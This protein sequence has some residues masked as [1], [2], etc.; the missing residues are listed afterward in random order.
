[1]VKNMYSLLDLARLPEK[2]P[3][4]VITATTIG[5][6]MVLLEVINSIIG[7]FAVLTGVCLT[8]VLIYTFIKKYRLES[9]KLNL[10]I[11][12]LA[13]ESEGLSNVKLRKE[14]GKPLRRQG[15]IK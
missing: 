13:E 5:G 4:V 12:I 9:K 10:E 1:M 2:N 15:D 11:D 6:V 3:E 14:Q 7:V 8:C